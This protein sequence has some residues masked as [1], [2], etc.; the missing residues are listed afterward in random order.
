MIKKSLKDI[1]WLVSEADY[2]AD[3]A[4]SYSTIASF[5]KG[6]FRQLKKVLDGEK[7]SSASLL[8]GSVVDTL[9][10]NPEEFDDLFIVADYDEPSDKVKNII[11]DVFKENFNEDNLRDVFNTYPESSL[12]IINLHKYG[13][14]NWK[15]ETKMNKII[16]EGNQYFALLQLTKGGKQIVSQVVYD[17]AL[18]CIKELKENKFT[19]WIFSNNDPEIE[20]FYQ[21][22]FK[23]NYN[24]EL[25]HNPLAWK[26]QLVEEDTIR[27]MFDAIVVD[28]KNKIIWPIDL[29]TTS[30]NEE[31]F[32][33][34][35]HD[36]FYDIQAGL[37][38]YVLKS[39]CLT[40]D[41]FKDF[42][43]NPFVFV[44]INKYNCNPQLYLWTGYKPF[45]DYKNVLHR[46]WVCL[47]Q[48]VRWHIEREEFRY[49][50][51]TVENKG[52]NH[53]DG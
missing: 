7:I 15:D 6:G 1:S 33:K 44:P 28:H 35:I 52:I 2:R 5:A 30:Y 17:S 26:E 3:K 20:V 51:S 47:L 50:R 16:E 42:T 45:K 31:E 29:K 43:I 37:Y 39:V 22:K 25:V 24:G 8:F 13:G 12:M 41:Y 32:I 40:D 11:D 34:G 48:D 46:N 21:L 53:V 36:W 9:L 19:S 27:C 18:R 10:T 49:S 38:H 23:I 4:L 14:D